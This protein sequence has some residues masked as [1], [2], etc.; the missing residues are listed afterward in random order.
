MK[1]IFKNLLILA[2]AAFVFSACEN[3]KLPQQDYLAKYKGVSAD[4]VYMVDGTDVLGTAKQCN[5]AHTPLG[6]QG[7]I[8]KTCKIALT[9]KQAS[10]VTV[11]LKQNDA[12]VYGSYE[13]FPA[14]VAK[15]PASITIPAGETEKEFEVTVDN[16]DFAKFGVGAYMLALSLDT[17]DGA[18]A[19]TNSASSYIYVDAKSIDPAN[20]LILLEAA[21]KT[22][23][24]VHFT[25][26]TRATNI[27][28]DL[29]VS[30][31]EAAFLPFDVEFEVANDLIAAYNTANGTE[32]LPLPAGVEV[33]L[34]SAHMA[35]DATTTKAT[36][37]IA[38]A[39]NDNRETV[40]L[41]DE[42]GYLVPIRIKNCSPAT[43]SPVESIVYVVINVTVNDYDSSYFMSLDLTNGVSGSMYANYMAPSPIVQVTN[44]KFMLSINFYADHFKNTGTTISRLCQWC[45]SN[46]GHS[47]MLRWG[48]GGKGNRLQVCGAMTGNFFVDYE[49]EEKKWYT[50]ILAGTGTN[51]DL[52]ANGTKIGSHALSRKDFTFQRFELGMSWGGYYSSQAFNGRVA[53]MVACT[54]DMTANRYWSNYRRYFKSIDGVTNTIKK[55]QSTFGISVKAHWP[56]N[57]GRGHIFNDIVGGFNMDWSDVWATPNESDYVHVDYSAA[58][59]AAWKSD[60]NNVIDDWK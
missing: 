24:I 59:D 6:E 34:P 26:E 58:I 30:G 9:K 46:E 1:K 48:E 57:E 22:Y 27:S 17:V 3:D 16:A 31:T 18:A 51:L 20:N 35:K 49:F 21:T 54:G 11:T 40:K 2:S 15:F 37:A 5:I 13:A 28:F 19:S 56:F 14:G 7:E 55:Y 29:N 47:I 33:T 50:L 43:L 25:N 60:S 42:P 12:L 32:Y 4:Y 38:E 53:N 41:V 44:G 39:S 36:F 10:A 8:S 52:Y 23:S 45:D